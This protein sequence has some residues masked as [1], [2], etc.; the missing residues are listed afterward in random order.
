MEYGPRV[1]C[2]R[3]PYSMTYIEN[4]PPYIIDPGV[5]IPLWSI[6]HYGIWMGQNSMGGPYS[7][8][9]YGPAGSKF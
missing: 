2:L 3:D 9:E 1:H 5:H 4:G 6:F 8:I 7:I